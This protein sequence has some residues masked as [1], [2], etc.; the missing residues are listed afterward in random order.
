MMISIEFDDFD[1]LTRVALSVFESCGVNC[2]Q[3]PDLLVK[4]F[5]L[6]IRDEDSYFQLQITRKINVR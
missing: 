6:S 1:K 5:R 2:N 4:G 3:S